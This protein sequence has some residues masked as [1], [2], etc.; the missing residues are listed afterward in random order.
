MVT[1]DGCGSTMVY[2]IEIGKLKCL[3]CGSVREVRCDDAA[4]KNA[5]VSDT[6]EVRTYTC[7][8][9][10]AR[11][12]TEDN[13]AVS[14]CSYCGAQ[15][16]L[17]DRLETVKKPDRIIPFVKTKKQ[18]EKIY[19]RRI[20]PA[21]YAPSAMRRRSRM[22]LF[23]GIYIPYYI[24]DVSQKNHF[25]IKTKEYMDHD[26]YINEPSRKYSVLMGDMSAEYKSTT[27]D[28]S[29][30]FPD[31]ISEY[32]SPYNMSDAKPFSEE[33]LN[34]FYA[35]I[36]NVDEKYYRELAIEQANAKSLKS[37][38]NY[39]YFKKYRLE[40]TGENVEALDMFKTRVVDVNT[41]MLP[42][43][44][45]VHNR[46]GRMSY[47]TI[48][49]QTGR[50]HADIPVEPW[51]FFAGS[52]LTAVLLYFLSSGVR[53]TSA[54]NMVILGI[55]LQFFMLMF[56]N[57]YIRKMLDNS[58][59]VTKGGRIKYRFILDMLLKIAAP[60]VSVIALLSIFWLNSLEELTII[61]ME[62]NSESIAV[63]VR[64]ITVLL[65]VL[66]GCYA[67]KTIHLADYV[68]EVEVRWQSIVA[69]VSLM[70]GFGVSLIQPSEDKWYILAFA[71]Q[72]VAFVV[73]MFVLIWAHNI[74][75]S[76]DFAEFA[77]AGGETEGK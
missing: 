32:I 45:T 67:I 52:V 61:T 42:V 30:I 5:G 73:F 16:V 15:S 56:Y 53:I 69:I 59:R 17:T 68:T 65:A 66:I 11:L 50:I 39:K 36:P 20:M 76:T 55:V 75:V 44:F 27:H 9:C 25:A 7:P 31:S 72:T 43:W 23:R 13:S 34:G 51:K 22:D 33:Y 70:C 28:A 64:I 1:C 37:I 54:P 63:L 29:S 8:S 18:C 77:K 4:N 26:A 60:V 74:C 2:D 71:I 49:G 47:S 10:G 58:E 6:F 3:Q 24:Y 35:D 62:L 38:K 48:N 41:A 40:E 14:F 57:G 19:R 21:L 46:K 12:A